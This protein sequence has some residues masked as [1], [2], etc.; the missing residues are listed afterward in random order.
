MWS[1]A[2]TVALLIIVVAGIYAATFRPGQDWGDDY[3]QYIANARNL[4]LGRPYAET[5][6][7]VTLPEAAIHMP[8]SYPPVFPLLLEPVY[9]RYGLNFSALQVPVQVMFV[10]AAAVFY[11][12]ARLRN[13]ELMPAAA[14]AFATAVSGVALTLKDLIFSDST[15]LF[16][17]GFSL[18]AM[19]WVERRG[20]D[21]K[22]P[23]PAAAVVSI[24][25]LLAYGSRSVGISLAA[26]FALYEAVVKRRI[27]LFSVAV[28]AGFGA[29]VVFYSLTPYGGRGYG[30]EFYFAPAVYWQ[31]TIAYGKA[32][33][34]LWA[35]APAPVRYF[36]MAATAAIAAPEWLRRLRS[37]PSVVEYFVV[38]SI[39]PVIFYPAGRHFRYILPVYPLYLIYFLEGAS[40]WS[41]RS[42]RAFTWASAGACVLLMAGSALALRGRER[43]PYLEGAERPTFVEA[44]QFVRDHTDPD[45]LV[46]FWKP[47]LLA[48][49]TNHRSG[50]YPYTDD[51][52]G[53]DEY[54]KS[55]GARYVLVYLRGED[56]GR[57][58][59]PHIRRQ[60]E[61]FAAVFTNADFQLYQ[62]TP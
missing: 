45:Q 61:R 48:L 60:P 5:R 4:A 55:A 25:M 2:G 58:L 30:T 54:L 56:D 13:V 43:G 16:F 3:A 8:S 50:W 49:C 23:L 15:Y 36:L 46:V 38:T 35:G 59:V 27:R 37:C 28:L 12:L 19:V 42:K 44:W 10:L 52:T 53:F 22:K 34:E 29:G 21:V 11:A 17:A 40:W 41:M 62:V 9:R 1:D 26:A 39:L 51:D 31:N 47:R 57:W 6:F 32:M 20:W 33:A 24:C 18:V 7:V 14:A